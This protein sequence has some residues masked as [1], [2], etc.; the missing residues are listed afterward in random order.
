MAEWG[1]KMAKKYKDSEVEV[2]PDESGWLVQFVV[3]T[4]VGNLIVADEVFAPSELSE[5]FSW[6][7]KTRL[8]PGFGSL[9]LLDG[10]RADNADGVFREMDFE[11]PDA[12]INLFEELSVAWGGD[13]GLMFHHF[14]YQFDLACFDNPKCNLRIKSIYPKNKE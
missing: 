7:E 14:Q 3:D 9:K 11:S 1:S 2:T 4:G 5:V 10:M 6:F 8:G 13:L 12:R